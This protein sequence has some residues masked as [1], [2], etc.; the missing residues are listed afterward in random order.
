V[1][2]VADRL[3]AEVSVLAVDPADQQLDVL[4]ELH[5]R[6]HGLAA[7]ARHLHQRHL[8]HGQAPVLEEL[9]E[10]LDA[11]Q[12]ALGRGP[13]QAGQRSDD[14]DAEVFGALGDRLAGPG[15]PGFDGR[16]S[17]FVGHGAYCAAARVLLGGGDVSHGSTS[18]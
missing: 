16:A 18:G 13:V 8:G 3:A 5:V 1:V 9:T 15:D 10:R 14:N 11:V 2:Q 4:A 6:A 17:R 7:R 12:D